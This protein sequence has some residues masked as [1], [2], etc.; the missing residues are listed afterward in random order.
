MQTEDLGAWVDQQKPEIENTLKTLVEI[1]TYTTNTA[2]VDQGMDTLS[3]I[4]TAMGMQ[5]E[6]I[7]GRHLLIRA[8]DGK[9]KPRILL[10]SH[11]DTVF[12]PDGD[13]LQ[14]EDSG[15]GFVQGPGTGDIKGGLVMGLWA[16]A[17]IQQ[18]CDD[19]DVQMI[20]SAD[21]EKGSVSI[22]DWYLNGH[23]GAD[24]A[25]GLEPGFPQGELSATVP[26]GVVYQRRGYGA[27]RFTV[28]G[29]DAHSGASELGLNAAEAMAHRILK[30]QALNDPERGISAN[31][32][33][34]HGG[35]SANTVPGSVDGLVSF[36]FFEQAHGDQL[37]ETIQ[38]IIR[39]RY[40]YNEGLDLWDHAELTVETFNPPM[41][42]SERNQLLID[43]VL[44][45]AKRLG[46][47]VVPIARGGGSDANF[48]SAA[49]TPAICGMGAP[50]KGIH[51]AQE[52]I[53]LPMLFERISLLTS[54]LYRLIQRHL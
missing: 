15:D 17:A 49:G 39:D 36:R 26:L 52:R 16:M 23:I 48:I 13:F 37:L 11:M 18:L 47:N 27:I 29:K 33:T 34:L 2:G 32:G 14:Y 12:P 22:R 6:T 53:Y 28:Y 45:E 50:A 19:V 4:A 35:I 20:V 42:S 10:I 43:I 8:G 1:N 51:T 54:T 46:Q 7:N 5:V 9:A 21:E 38:N 40:I 3:Q 31:I 30:I 24:Y 41:E 25:I 44:E